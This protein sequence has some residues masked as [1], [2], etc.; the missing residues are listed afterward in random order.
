MGFFGIMKE[1]GFF[2]VYINNKVCYFVVWV[3][4]LFI[5]F[6]WKII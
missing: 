2:M 6:I 1:V 3:G 5:E 4:Y